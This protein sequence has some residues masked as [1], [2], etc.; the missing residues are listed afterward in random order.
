MHVY[1][2]SCFRRRVFVSFTKLS[3]FIYLFGSNMIAYMEHFVHENEPETMTDTD[4]SRLVAAMNLRGTIDCHST[5][6]ASSD[7]GRLHHTKPLAVIRPSGVDDISKVV[8]FAG[9]STNLTVAARGNGHSINGQ[10]MSDG[11]FVIDMQSTENYAFSVKRLRGVAVA[12]VSG[13]V[14]WEE[15][16]KRCVLEYGLAPRSWTDYLGLSVGGTISNAGV[17]GQAFRYG[18]QTSNVTEL[19]VVIGNGDIV[20]CS[21]NQSSELF[22]SVLGGLGQF[23]IINRASILLQPAPEMVD[24]IIFLSFIYRSILSY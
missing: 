19:E 5:L 2:H 7:F 23:G 22:Y 17:S 18:P 8:K 6:I 13:G 1:I 10:A 16:L 4:E 3:K 20:T 12:D 15:V 9:N 14:L 11:G 21:E 24:S